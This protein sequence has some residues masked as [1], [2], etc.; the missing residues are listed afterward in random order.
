MTV[1]SDVYV[2]ILLTVI[3]GIGIVVLSKKIDQ[4]DPLQEPRASSCR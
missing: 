2:I 1:Q 4:T 3:L